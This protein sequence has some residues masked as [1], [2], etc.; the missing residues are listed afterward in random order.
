VGF[1]G[2]VSGRDGQERLGDDDRKS[3]RHLTANP[4]RS[5]SLG[6]AE[7]WPYKSAGQETAKETKIPKGKDVENV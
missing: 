7:A 3:E 5:S 2:A 1:V 4:L 6:F